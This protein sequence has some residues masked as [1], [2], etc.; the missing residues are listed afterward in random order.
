MNCLG[1]D[2]LE[3]LHQQ[4]TKTRALLFHP[5][6]RARIRRGDVHLVRA[7]W[8]AYLPTPDVPSFLQ[9]VGLMY[10]H[11]IAEGKGIVRVARHL[12]LSFKYYPEAAD[13]C[14]TTGVMLIKSHGKKPLFS[15]VFYDKR[16][17][18]ADMK[19]GKSLSAQETATLGTTSAST[20][21]CIPPASSPSSAR[22]GGGSRS[23]LQSGPASVGPGGSNSSRAIPNPASGSSNAQ[24]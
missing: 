9:T 10:D 15:L 16:Q 24:C 18:A 13:A 21:P 20:S 14:D 19:Q 6:T 3:Q 1:F 17:R 7:Q 4:A 8:C 5:D 23:S 22:R 12:G 11:A 2:L